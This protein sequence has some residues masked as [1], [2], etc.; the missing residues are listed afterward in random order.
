MLPWDGL[1]QPERHRSQTQQRRDA[2]QKSPYGTVWKNQER[3]GQVSCV[4]QQAR[5]SILTNN[6][7]LATPLSYLALG[8]SYTIGESVAEA[9]RW[10]I[11]LA[12]ALASQEIPVFPPRIIARTGWTTSE[13]QQAID[14]ATFSDRYDLVSLLIGVNNQYRGQSIE[15]Y[16][17]EFR[18]LLDFAISKSA[19]GRDRVFVVSIPDYAYTP[20]GE[21]QPEITAGVNDFNAAASEICMVA[22]VPFYNITTISREG[23]NNPQL[24]ADDGLH[25]SGEHYRRWVEE[26]ILPGVLAFF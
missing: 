6:R 24:V 21:G 5:M 19:T 26:V 8:D 10:P 22:G 2:P 20:F 11:Q 1:R 9:Q 18:E 23:L 14:A 12:A 15:S 16:R 7:P 3:A 17:A 25:P 4:L 13:L